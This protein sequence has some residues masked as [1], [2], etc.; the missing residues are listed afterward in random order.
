MI[1]QKGRDIL[2]QMDGGIKESNIKVVS[3][4]GVNVF[5]AGSAIFG[6]PDYAATISKMKTLAK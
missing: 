4:S 5:V 3:D 6:S 1:Q 2:I